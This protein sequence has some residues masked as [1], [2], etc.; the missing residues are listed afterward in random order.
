MPI[1]DAPGR[2]SHSPST[3]ATAVMSST[4]CAAYNPADCEAN[5]KRSDVITYWQT[6]QSSNHNTADSR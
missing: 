4:H 1:G 3:D 6:Q 2:A 5:D